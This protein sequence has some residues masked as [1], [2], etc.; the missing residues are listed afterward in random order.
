M[1]KSATSGPVEFQFQNPLKV[2]IGSTLTIHDIDYMGATF[3]VKEIHEYG[4]VIPGEKPLFFTDY[5]CCSRPLFGPEKQVRIRLNPVAN[6]DAAAGLTHNVILMTQYDSLAYNEGL[7][8]CVKDDTK[9]FET[10]V[11]GNLTGRY[12]RIN[13][14]QNSYKADVSVI[15]ARPDGKVFMEDVQ[16]RGLEYWDYWSE[17]KDEA[18]QPFTKFCFVEMNSDT[19]WFTIWQ[20]K[21]IDAQHVTC[22]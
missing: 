6:P 5:D 4:R 1:L 9:L 20:G 15:T 3:F 2:K 14:V 12:F 13:D 21:E 7:H 19:G 18:G 17:V 22:Y 16:K 8:N 11:D 10:F